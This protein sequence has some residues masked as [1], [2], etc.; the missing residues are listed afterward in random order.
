M[1]YEKQTFVDK[2]TVLTAEHLNHIEQ[3]IVDVENT[4]DNLTAEDVGARPNTWKPSLADIGAAPSGYGLGQIAY[5]LP[6][7]TDANT[8]TCNGWYLLG[9][10]A[11]N[12]FGYK[13]V[14][15]VDAYSSSQLIQTLYVQGYS[16]KTPIVVQRTCVE[17]NWSEWAFV[18]PPMAAGVEY[19]TTERFDGKPVYVK[20]VDFGN[21]PSN[22][23]K[24]VNFSS[25]VVSAVR[26]E[27]V[28]KYPT[29][30]TYLNL[31]GAEGVASVQSM[32]NKI[33]ITTN[34]TSLVNW[35]AKVMV[36]YTKD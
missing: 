7:V 27:G 1:A 14:M 5:N 17:S 13:G 16:T 15:R 19:R 23:Y 32:L 24:D 6:E 29:E 12:G 36:Y 20:L 25:V 18:N 8:A 30:E 28:L 3:G 31:S 21:L 26:M 11:A 2:S 33:R 34:T 4:V 35:T 9:K 10:D 22:T